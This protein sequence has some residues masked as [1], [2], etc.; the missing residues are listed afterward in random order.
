MHAPYQGAV[1]WAAQPDPRSPS[2]RYSARQACAQHLP[3]LC[4]AQPATAR[5][6]TLCNRVERYLPELFMFV[7]DPAVP[8]TNNAA[9]RALRPL[10]IARKISGGTRSA[11]GS[12]TR[13]ILQSL[14]DTWEV[15]GQ[16]PMA[17]VQALLQAPRGCN[18]KLAPV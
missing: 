13:M 15:R 9:E 2:Q 6:A 12:R 7:A 11:Q 18:Q 5:Q 10:V 3:E 14:V 1:S 8:A 16:D 4:R 17:A